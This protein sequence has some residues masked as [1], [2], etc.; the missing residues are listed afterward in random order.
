MYELDFEFD[1]YLKSYLLE[2]IL[3]GF[4]IVD[5]G[6]DIG[7]YENKNYRST[8]F[9]EGYKFVDCF[10]HSELAQGKYMMVSHKPTCIHSLG[11][12]PK[13][14]GSIRVIT[15]CSRPL[16]YSIYNFMDTTCEYFRYRTVDEVAEMMTYGS[17]M[18]SVDIAAAYRSIPIFPAH[19]RYKV[20]SWS[21]DGVTDSFLVD[22][23]IC[24]GQKSAP[25]IFDKISFFVMRCMHR[26]GIHKIFQNLDD[27]IVFGDTW[28]E[29]QRAQ[30]ILIHLLISLGFRISWD[31]CSSP[32]LEIVYLGVIFDS[33]RMEL[34]MPPKKLFKLRCELQFFRNKARCT[35][36]QLQKLCGRIAHISKVVKGGRTFSQR[37]IEK[38]K[39]LSLGNP[40]IRLP[41]EFQCD[42]SWWLN[43]M[44]RFNGSSW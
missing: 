9:G 31:K 41:R 33:L 4:K 18:A 24:F 39:G 28:Q 11:F 21:F 40:C 22:T 42:I 19:R 13:S 12:V 14:S 2:G 29:C 34:R 36:K 17:F 20:I 8:W 1:E 23:H 15:D 3:F 26:R 10:P 5:T 43:F 38:L 44:D 37:L 27:F 25:F 16:N 32:S 35:K 6:T 7:P 30:K